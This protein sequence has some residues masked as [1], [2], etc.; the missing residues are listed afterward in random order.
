M[1]SFAP[2]GVSLRPTA[3]AAT[4]PIFRQSLLLFLSL[5]IMVSLSGVVEKALSPAYYQ[6]QW[7]AFT[8]NSYNYYHPMFRAGRCV[9]RLCYR[10][11][12]CFVCCLCLQW[13]VVPVACDGLVYNFELLQASKCLSSIAFD[14]Q[15]TPGPAVSLSLTDSLFS[16]FL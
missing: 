16:L 4:T 12:V 13:K 3:A 14:R 1:L 8:I 10:W 6:Q 2:L 7:K 15:I 5:A 9:R 11:S